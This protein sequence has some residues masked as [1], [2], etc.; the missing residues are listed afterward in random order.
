MLLMLFPSS[1][2]LVAP[3]ATV[4]RPRA[5]NRVLNHIV[6]NAI[7]SEVKRPGEKSKENRRTRRDPQRR[8]NRLRSDRGSVVER[9]EDRGVVKGD[10]DANSTGLVVH[11][12]SSPANR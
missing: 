12:S 1:S 9:V 2:T 5:D 3:K 10:Q 8:K 11:Y 4:A 7:E 6:P